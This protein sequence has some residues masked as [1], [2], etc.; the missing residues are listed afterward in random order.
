M[1]LER[2]TLLEADI[3]GLIRAARGR[4]AAAGMGTFPEKPLA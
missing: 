4:K 3:P 2:T 1:L